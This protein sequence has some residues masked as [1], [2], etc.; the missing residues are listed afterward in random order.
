[1]NKIMSKLSMGLLVL[2]LS[3]SGVAN[4]NVLAGDKPTDILSS[5]GSRVLDALPRMVNA[6]LGVLTAVGKL[7][8]KVPVLYYAGTAFR[9]FHTISEVVENPTEVIQKQDEHLAGDMVNGVIATSVGAGVYFF[10]MT[11]TLPAV[12]ALFA[13]DILFGGNGSAIDWVKK[14]IATRIDQFRGVSSQQ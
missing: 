14:S 1:M 3:V 5:L 2:S 12:G 7:D 4:A 13:A 9:S 10:G 8:W 6:G 11:A